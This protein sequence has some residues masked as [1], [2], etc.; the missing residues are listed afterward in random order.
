MAPRLVALGLWCA[1]VTAAGLVVT[2][3]WPAS[4]L[5]AFVAGSLAGHLA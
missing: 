2:G 3:S 5:L 1:V 4:L